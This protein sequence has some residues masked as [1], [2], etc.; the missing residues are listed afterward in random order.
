MSNNP[1]T[2]RKTI[3]KFLAVGAATLLLTLIA[4]MPAKSANQAFSIAPVNPDFLAYQQGASTEQA[5][6][7]GLG[8]IPAPWKMP[9]VPTDTTVAVALPAAFDLRDSGRVTPVRNQ[10]TSGSCWT[11]ATYGSME[12]YLYSEGKDFSENNL[13]N[14]SGF[15]LDPNSSGGNSTMATAYLA[16]WNGPV[17]EAQDPF[18]ETSTTSPTYAPQKHVQ[19]VLFLTNNR[20]S[21]KQH[22]YDNGAL[23]AAFCW[24]AANYK[25]ATYSF[26]APAAA[27]ANHAITVVGWD[28]NYAASNFK[29]APPGN[30]AY[31]V[32]NSWG[33]SW[34]QSGYFYIS[35][36]DAN[37]G[38]FAA[39]HNAEATDNY[40]RVY[41][42]DPLGVVGFLGDGSTTSCV[43]ANVFTSVANENLESVAFYTPVP[44]SSYTIRIYTDPSST[45][46]SGTLKTTQSGTITDAGYHTVKLNTA[47]TLRAGQKYAIAVTLNT[48]GYTYPIGI[49]MPEADYSSNATASA[50]QSYISNDGSTWGDV[51][52]YIS[53]A[54][55]CI[56]GFTSFTASS[57][58]TLSSLFLSSGSLTPG[59]SSGTTSYTAYAGNWVTSL[60]VT[61]TATQADATIKVNGTTVASGGTSGSI[62]LAVG[63]N[64]LNV[65]VTAQDGTTTKTYTITVTRAASTDAT[66]SNLTISSGTLSPAFAPTTPSYTA[67]VGNG[68]SSLTV[69]PTVNQG[70]ATVKVNGTTVASGSPSGAI[71]LA[72]GSNTINVVVTA[73]DGTTTKTYAITVTRAA[74]QDFSG[75]WNIR[76]KNSNLVM[77][78]YGGGK[79]QGV[80]VIQWPYHGMENQQWK[81]EPLGNGYYKITSVLSGM[82]I[83]VYGGGT[84]LGNRVIQWPYHGGTN[85]QWK[86]LENA[87][88]TV[89]LVSRLAVESGTG[90]VL[91]VY[92][93]GKDQGVNVIQ[94]TPN[95]GDN[96]KWYLDA[97]PEYT[98]SYESNGGTA[99]TSGKV[100]INRLLTEPIP[101]T[102][103][104]V[105]FG[106]WYK[107]AALTQKWNFTKDRMPSSNLTL[108]AK[109]EADHSGTWNIRS[110]NS[111]LLMDVYGVGTEQGVNVIQWPSNGGANQKWNFISL[112]N[113][114][115][116]ITSVLSGLSLDVYG[117]NT[118]LGNR[119]IQWPWHGGSNQQWRIIENADGTVS[120]MSRLSE[121]SGAGYLL[122]VYGGGKDQGVNVIQWTAHYGDN[123]KWYLDAL[124]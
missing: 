100:G 97:V 3:S 64:T 43:G 16:R 45:P 107:D 114:Y 32:K 19:D 57:D 10:G 115:Y 85:Q 104:G 124:R 109:W 41:A 60:T 25:D 22:L 118:D 8:F 2:N 11:F 27:D 99:I 58:A 39:F 29:T 80:N 70:N 83:D 95:N 44:G 91:D 72:V 1:S 116:K 34:G 96:Q 81:F 73:Q 113:G 24:D 102:K 33:T 61:P 103:T 21:I 75:T 69:T 62:P 14:N 18:V 89:S 37:L 119:V 28:D 112:G 67:A 71:S 87:D 23:S 38:Y 93:G 117:G 108:Y 9:T 66:L 63:S 79:D 31:I 7:H 86:I 77:D 101:P 47:V 68:V 84:D 26:Y 49:E 110:K 54:N 98:L 59:F 56:K 123:Q 13:K 78:V 5:G 36:Y 88:G 106:G 74:A 90:F 122:D 6:E 40:D 111:A 55:I 105:V 4:S 17:S 65:V 35:Y 48:P 50:G 82:S 20:D 46:S 76:S 30:G 94:W 92:G 12:S 15:D 53:N 51:T 121:E 42:Y 120:L 52:S